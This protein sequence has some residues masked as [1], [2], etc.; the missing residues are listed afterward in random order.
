MSAIYH[1]TIN[2]PWQIV[3]Q[4]ETAESQQIVLRSHR[5]LEDALSLY[6][7][8][9]IGATITGWDLPVAQREIT[10]NNDGTGTVTITLETPQDDTGGGGGGSPTLVATYYELTRQELQRN[11]RALPA[12]NLSPQDN[13]V[14]ERALAGIPEAVTEAQAQG[15]IW[16]AYTKIIRGQT[17][18]VVYAPVILQR[19]RFT[20]AAPDVSASNIGK[21]HTAA[22][23][24]SLYGIPSSLIPSSYASGRKWLQTGD[25]LIRDR[26]VW[27]HTRRFVG[28]DRW[29]N[30]VDDGVYGVYEVVT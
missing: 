17:H 24:Q 29:D 21:V 15:N 28:A 9:N 25:E 11:I 13:L 22:Q 8:I 27:T 26:N 19:R 14:L 2:Q 12:I 18:Y 4:R 1:G 3:S 20:G 16:A 30:K 10:A 7:S 23:L 6:N 5:P